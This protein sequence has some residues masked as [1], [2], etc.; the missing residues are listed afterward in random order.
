ML[1]IYYIL[2]FNLIKYLIILSYMVPCH[3][4]KI[5]QRGLIICHAHV[6]SVFAFLPHEKWKCHTNEAYISLGAHLLIVILLYLDLFFTCS[7]KCDLRKK[8]MLHENLCHN[9]YM[10]SSPYFKYTS[11]YTRYLNFFQNT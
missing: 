2:R 1:C 3:Y 8:A 6:Y 7:L 11:F 4:K 9:S 5:F 10:Q